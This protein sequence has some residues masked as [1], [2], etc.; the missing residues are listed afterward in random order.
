MIAV[1]GDIHGNLWA[2]EAVLAELDRRGPRQVIVAGDLAFGGPRPAECVALIQR[3]GYPT[4]RGNT[5]EWLRTA[6]PHVHD[7]V[8]WTSA[9]LNDE[10]RR[11]LAGLP[12]Q[13]RVS[14]SPG[15][16]V[17]VHAT[18][19]SIGEVVAPDAPLAVVERVFVEAKAAAVAYGHIHIAYVRDLGEHLLVNAGSVGLPAD[20][21][22]RASFV[23]LEVRHGKWVATLQRISYDLG[24]ALAAARASENPEADRWARRLAAASSAP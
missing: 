23:E 15:D 20:G 18:P 22:P 5:D 16:L 21:D 10:H 9:Q 19:W 8:S 14:Q 11:F 3:R 4:I 2:L 24:A 13:W 1:L 7:A 17:V 6:P 12:L